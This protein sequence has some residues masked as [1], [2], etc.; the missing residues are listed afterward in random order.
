MHAAREGDIGT[1]ADTGA[2]RAVTG[3]GGGDGQD[4][5]DTTSVRFGQHAIDAI[6]QSIIIQAIEMAVRID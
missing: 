4:K 1:I 6:V 2:H 5:P 3:Q